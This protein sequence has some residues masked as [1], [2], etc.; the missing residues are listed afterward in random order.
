MT[1]DWQTLE[2]IAATTGRTPEA[3]IQ[4]IRVEYAAG[5]VVCQFIEN[6]K[7]EWRKK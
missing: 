5:R 4:E 7:V 6:D 1:N 2:Q 3:V